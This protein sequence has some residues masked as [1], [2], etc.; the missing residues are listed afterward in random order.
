MYAL[1]WLQAIPWRFVTADYG[2]LSDDSWLPY[3]GQ[4]ADALVG[5]DAAPLHRKNP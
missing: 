2:S 3:S 4:N 1:L 5:I